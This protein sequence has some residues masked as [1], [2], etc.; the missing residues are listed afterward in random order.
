MN[1]LQTIEYENANAVVTAETMAD[2]LARFIS[3]AD[4]R[5]KSKDTYLRCIK[6]FFVF[7]RER[8]I[9]SPNRE[10]V[11]AWREQ[12]KAEN[13]KP[14]TIQ[15]YLMAVRCFFKW[16]ADEGLYSNIAEHVKNVNV[17]TD[18]FKRDY[19]T[20]SQVHDIIG[21]IDT[22]DEKGARDYALLSLMVTTGLR[23]IE[24]ERANIEDIKTVAGNS[25]LFIQGKGRD[26]KSEYV[27][28]A[29]AVEK[30]IRLYLSFRGALD[31]N[32]PLFATTGNRNKAGRMGT[33]SIRGIVKA[34]F[35][36]SGFDSER[37]TAHSLRHTAGTLALLN[38]A[39]T[40]EVQQM[41]RHKN[42]N[43]TMIYS[44]EL[45]RNQNNSELTVANAIF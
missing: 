22:S 23:T 13:K 38:G 26:E 12:L 25:V 29:P 1:E 34:H 32:A 42:I 10:H 3:F 40:R 19:L 20:A 4:V 15:T 36:E 18:I 24:I 30:A 6:Q 44:H 8:G 35:R 21:G 17:K 28:L 33:R 16:L 5:E 14:T 31:K 39:S 11:I 2:L 9:K 45:D 43:T 7:M 41:L 37:L 27:K